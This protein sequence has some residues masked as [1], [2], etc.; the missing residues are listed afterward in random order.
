MGGWLRE[1][2]EGVRRRLSMVWHRLAEVTRSTGRVVCTWLCAVLRSLRNAGA[3]LLR[4]L[5]WVLQGM[6]SLAIRW[7]KVWLPLAGV[8]VFGAIPCIFYG[9]LLNILVSRAAQDSLAAWFVLVLSQLIIVSWFWNWI[10]FK[11]P[12]PMALK[13][14]YLKAFYVLSTFF[15]STTLF[16]CAYMA[17]GKLG[18]NVSDSVTGCPLVGFWDHMRFSILT[19]TTLGQANI[20][21]KGISCVLECAEIVQFWFLIAIAGWVLQP[22]DAG[23]PAQIDD[24]LKLKAQRMPSPSR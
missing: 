3:F 17:A 11:R 23:T 13:G 18:D 2:G 8:V 1:R 20:A 10:R 21:T 15:L 7:G 24:L 5:L 12:L 14:G 16:A 9:A 22:G 4:C 19:A 6:G